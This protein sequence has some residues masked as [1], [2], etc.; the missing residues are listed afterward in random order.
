MEYKRLIELLDKSDSEAEALKGRARDEILLNNLE[1]VVEILSVS[2]DDI[3]K[4]RS[5]QKLPEWEIKSLLKR[6][7]PCVMDYYEGRYVFNPAS[8]QAFLKGWSLSRL[9]G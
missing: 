5:E 3:M 6:V 4:P 7:L 2:L 8:A 1:A 9:R